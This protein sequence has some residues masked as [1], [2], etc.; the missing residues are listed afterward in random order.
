M[1]F[2]L[3]DNWW[4]LRIYYTYRCYITISFVFTH[5]LLSHWNT[6]ATFV[7]IYIV[8]IAEV[9]VVCAHVFP[10]HK[11]Y[12]CSYESAEIIKLIFNFDYPL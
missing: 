12:H 9:M 2:M 10:D 1:Y 5:D 8:I 3:C 6:V 11:L 7:D 4:V